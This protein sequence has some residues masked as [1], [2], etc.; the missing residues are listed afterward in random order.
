MKDEN[1]VKEAIEYLDKWFAQ[2]GVPYLANGEYY[3][4]EGNNDIFGL[5]PKGTTTEKLFGTINTNDI[6]PFN[7]K[8]DLLSTDFYESRGEFKIN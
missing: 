5:C 1:R 2:I 8:G 7:W 3:F 6:I 4:I